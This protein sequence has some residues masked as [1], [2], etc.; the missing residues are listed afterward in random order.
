MQLFWSI[1]HFL[2]IFVI[3]FGW[4]NSKAT[5][6]PP[7]RDDK[8]GQEMFNWSELHS[9]SSNFLQNPYFSD[10]FSLSLDIKSNFTYLSRL[11]PTHPHPHNKGAPRSKILSI[12]NTWHFCL[13]N[14]KKSKIK[15]KSQKFKVSFLGV[16]SLWDDCTFIL[17]V[18]PFSFWKIIIFI[19]YFFTS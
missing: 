10:R 12:H 1:E 9:K 3:T 17:A 15:K 13:K 2:A 14:P 5:P 11:W 16:E 19:F 6:N 4:C 7:K 18:F 8:N